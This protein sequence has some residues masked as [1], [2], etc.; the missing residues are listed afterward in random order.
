MS[1]NYKFVPTDTTATVSQ[2]IERYEEITGR[3][4][5]SGDPDRLFI[6]WVADIIDAR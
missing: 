3:T 4:L 2:L 5:Q 1:N 6:L